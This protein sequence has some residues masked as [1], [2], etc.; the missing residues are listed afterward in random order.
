LVLVF[1]CL[2][3]S[4]RAKRNRAGGALRER[5]RSTTSRTAFGARSNGASA[6][7]TTVKRSSSR[8][9]GYALRN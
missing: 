2:E 9:S 5:I 8:D 6:S 1:L 4:R 7:H 3:T